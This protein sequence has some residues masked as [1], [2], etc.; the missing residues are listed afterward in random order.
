MK[1]IDYLIIGGGIAGTTAAEFIRMQ[2]STGSVS[3]VAEEPELLYSRVLLP[4]FLRDQIPFE[5]LYIRKQEHYPEKNIVLIKGTKVSKVNT[6]NKE[7]ELDNGEIIQYENILIASGGKV[8]KLN[9]PGKDLKGVTYLRTVEDVKEIN[10]FMNTAKTAAVIGGGF[11]GIEYAQ[12]FVK[13]GLDTTCF[14]RESF[15]WQNVV[16]ENMGKLLTNILEKNGVKITPEAEITEFMG[17]KSLKKIRTKKGKEI[18]ADIVGVGIGIHL[19]L[20]YLKGSGI[21]IDKGVITNEYLETDTSN[22][23]AA[24]DIAQFFDVLFEKSHG[25]GNWS[26]AAAQGKT[27]GSNMVA[28]WESVKREIFATVSAYTIGIFDN[29]FTF[30]GD[31]TV[32][33]TTVLIERGSVKENKLGRIYVK[34]GIITGAV[35]LN[36][37]ADRRVI[38]NLIKNRVN[39]ESNKDKITDISYNL[40]N[41]A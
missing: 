18:E 31:P 12:S 33:K 2:D 5:R 30:M 26:N 9:I 17:N 23:W 39:I 7:V 34:E 21:R 38:E 35:L 24:G 37:P 20:D 27:V 25:L 3:I 8:N 22:V 6:Q 29:S 15:F 40:N 41:L 4:H 36:L 13:A 28:G 32:D 16:G 10:N 11:I 14:I 1:K 19:D